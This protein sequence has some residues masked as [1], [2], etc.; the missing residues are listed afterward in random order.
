M[1]GERS[2]TTLPGRGPTSFEC[3][4]AKCS[5]TFS[6][7]CLACLTLQSSQISYMFYKYMWRSYGVDYP[8]LQFHTGYYS[9]PLVT[10]L[11]LFYVACRRP[12]HSPTHSTGWCLDSLWFSRVSFS[13][14]FFTTGDTGSVDSGIAGSVSSMEIPADLM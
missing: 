7:L 2:T 5:V 10:H 6:A 3:V 1:P 13:N 12:Y 8:L 4:C 9:D 11:A 14:S